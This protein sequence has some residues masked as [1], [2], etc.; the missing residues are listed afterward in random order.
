MP[1]SNPLARQLLLTTNEHIYPTGDG[2][3]VAGAPLTVTTD[4]EDDTNAASTAQ[5]Y[6]GEPIVLI[7]PATLTAVWEFIGLNFFGTTTADELRCQVYRVEHA[8]AAT[9]AA[10]NAWDEAATVLT[11]NS[12]AAAAEFVA[13]DLV[14]IASSAYVPNGEILKVASQTGATVTLA[15]ETVAAGANN[16]GLR[17]AHTTNIGAGTLIMY[18]CWRDCDTCHS[19]SFDYSA[20]T[21]KEHEREVMHEPRHML[22]NDGI[23]IRSHNATDAG[24]STFDCSAIYED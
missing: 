1:V 16:T 10:G 9:R 15:R 17:W 12:A 11:V 23:I 4:S 5:D 19:I 21:A 7:P 20:A 22:A 3:G 13:D 14:W 24:T 8:T 6:W 2:E 18:R